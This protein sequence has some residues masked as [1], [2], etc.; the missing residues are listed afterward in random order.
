MPGN[1]F[2]EFTLTLIGGKYREE[3]E[4]ITINAFKMW[5][6]QIYAQECPLLIIFLCWGLG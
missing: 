1:K 5:S 3:K 6:R 4:N 2:P